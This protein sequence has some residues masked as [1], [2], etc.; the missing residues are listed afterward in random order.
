MTGENLWPQN[1]PPPADAELVGFTYGLDSVDACEHCYTVSW[2]LRSVGSG[3]QVDLSARLSASISARLGEP[4]RSDSFGVYDVGG[5]SYELGYGSRRLHPNTIELALHGLSKDEFNGLA[6]ARWLTSALPHFDAFSAYELSVG[7]PLDAE[8]ESSETGI[9]SF[10]MVDGSAADHESLRT[11]LT[12]A[13]SYELPGLLVFSEEMTQLRTDLGTA[14]R[15]RAGS[16]DV[17]LQLGA[18]CSY[19]GFAAPT[20]PVGDGC[21]SSASTTIAPASTT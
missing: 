2:F 19:L 16:R 12:D 10:D 20:A 7:L 5:L 11:E 4:P 8:A 14:I 17:F 9:A 18:G 3:D 6:A 21:S 1:V 15:L 13:T